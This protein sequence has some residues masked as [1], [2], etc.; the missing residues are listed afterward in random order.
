MTNIRILVYKALRKV[1][2]AVRG[3]FDRLFTVMRF[4]GNGVRYQSFR[5]NG[6]PYVMVAVGGKM[7]IGRDFRMNNGIAG[8]P[9]GCFQPCTFVVDREAELRIGDHVG[10]SQSALI[11]HADIEI[12]NNVKIGGVFTYIP[13]ISIR[14]IQR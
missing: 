2:H 13:P 1:G 8:N 10:I 12:Q 14:L 9:I 3:L 11:A 7:S 6:V 4:V 5:T